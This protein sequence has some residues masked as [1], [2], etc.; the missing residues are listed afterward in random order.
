MKLIPAS[1]KIRFGSFAL[2][3]YSSSQIFI[4]KKPLLKPRVLRN[5]VTSNIY[6][7]FSKAPKL[8]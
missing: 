7:V 3:N 8:V 2:R 5:E 6:T 4:Q 1:I